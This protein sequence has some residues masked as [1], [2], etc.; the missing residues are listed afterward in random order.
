M[1]A[2]QLVQI[3]LGNPASCLIFPR[4]S[5]SAR[6]LRAS[7]RGE[8][9]LEVV[10]GVGTRKMGCDVAKEGIRAHVLSQV[11]YCASETLIGV[12]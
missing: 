9:H 5:I 6:G 8:I 2:P 7:P 11:K 10:V 12:L 3:L 1:M 4:L